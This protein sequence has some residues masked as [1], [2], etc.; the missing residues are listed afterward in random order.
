MRCG[1]GGGTRL[2]IDVEAADGDSVGRA[3]CFVHAVDVRLLGV[4]LG[5]GLGL[6][7]RLTGASSPGGTLGKG[8]KRKRAGD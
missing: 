5:L 8:A 1:G 4:G 2:R 6:W 7:P 3:V